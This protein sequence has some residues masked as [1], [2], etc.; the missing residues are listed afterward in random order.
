MTERRSL[1]S[2]DYKD[3]ISDMATIDPEKKP[4][5]AFA[6]LQVIVASVTLFLLYRFLLSSEGVVMGFIVLL[7]W[8]VSDPLHTL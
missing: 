5:A 1:R 3:S 8:P 6:V 4:N 7:L 2:V